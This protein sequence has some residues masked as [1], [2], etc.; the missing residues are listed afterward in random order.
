MS[1]RLERLENR[2]EV[3]PEK[4]AQLSE[5]TAKYFANMEQR[6]LDN[7]NED[8]ATAITER[9]ARIDQRIDNLSNRVSDRLN[10]YADRIQ[11]QLE[12]KYDS[13]VEPT[14]DAPSLDLEA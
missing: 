14:G 9:A 1:D 7:G 13:A 11:Q 5:E 4:L 6:A 8:L 2:S 10:G 12:A 3:I